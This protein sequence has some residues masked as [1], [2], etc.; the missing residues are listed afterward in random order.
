M[1]RITPPS[2]L[3]DAPLVAEAKG[4]HKKATIAAIS[5]GAVKRLSRDDGLML[6]KNSFSICAGDLFCSLPTSVNP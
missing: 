1:E 4:L 5:S 6:S 2:T 3:T